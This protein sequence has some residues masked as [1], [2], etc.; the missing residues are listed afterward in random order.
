MVISLDIL[1]IKNLFKHFFINNI[2]NEINCYSKLVF[3][4]IIERDLNKYIIK[5]YKIKNENYKSEIYTYIFK[6]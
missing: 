3:K 2:S 1:L 4:N 5:I 6:I